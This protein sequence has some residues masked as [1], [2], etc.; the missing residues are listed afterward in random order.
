MA[1]LPI[2]YFE[3]FLNNITFTIRI[4][5]RAM[6]YKRANHPIIPVRLKE[7]GARLVFVFLVL[8][9]TTANSS[10]CAESADQNIRISYNENV[11][12]IWAKDAD[13]NKVLFEIADETN[14][15]VQLLLPLDKKIT[16]NRS[17][18]SLGDGLGVILKSYNYIILYSGIKNN[19]P[20]ISKVIVFPKSDISNTLTDAE[21]QRA[22]GEIQFTNT[23]AQPDNKIKAYEKQ[24]E[25]FKKKLSEIDE[26]SRQGK[27]YSRRIKRLEKL[28]EMHESQLNETE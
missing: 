7:A 23:K 11:L 22:N 1:P 6:I 3:W 28:I 12:S 26:N 4:F 21:L 25:F 20:L 14:I 5:L 18:I 2:K 27:K 13:L 16:I 19:K 24:I 10:L 15:N 9:L 17:G 8:L